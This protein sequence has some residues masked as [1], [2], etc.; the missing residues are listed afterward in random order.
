M[1]QNSIDDEKKFIALALKEAKKGFYT[2]LP[3]PRVGCVLVKDGVII[4]SGYHKK[5]GTPH[6]EVNALKDA[7]SKGNSVEGAT[8]YV[9]LEPCSH[10]GLTPPCAKAL[11]D[12]KVGRVVCAIVDPNP[13]VKGKGIEILEK[14]GISV[15]HTVLEKEAYEINRDFFYAM[16]NERPYITVKYGMS[17]DAKV[18]LSNGVSKW[19][20]SDASR[21]DVQEL[22]AQSQVILTTAKT[23]LDDD[24]SMSL[25]YDELADEVKINYPK[26]LIRYPTKVVLDPKRVL[27]YS[28]NIFSS[29]GEVIVVYISTDGVIH[30]KTITYNGKTITICEIPAENKN[31]YNHIDLKVL[32]HYLHTK[33]IRSV[34]VEA[35]GNFVNQLIINK[36]VNKF[37]LYI[38]PKILGADGQNAFL[39][40]GCTDLS[41][42]LSLKLVDEQKIENDI[43]LTYEL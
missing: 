19:I 27:K 42:V 5:A 25:R 34:L 7:L 16:E 40:K 37:V 33:K 21:K 20:T 18:A 28:E 30:E 12:A 17:L 32:C 39:L 31:N 6:A 23:V 35:G 26:E 41:T 29:D 4:G 10:Y 24:P 22:R 11:V 15:T 13:L 9:T 2:T 1:F 3:N 38:A 8:A 43:R 36:L 14:A